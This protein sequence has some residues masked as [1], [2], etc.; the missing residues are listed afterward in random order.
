MNSG[1]MY[2][3]LTA[4]E[5]ADLKKDS[6]SKADVVWRAEGVIGTLKVIPRLAGV[7][8]KGIGTA[9]VADG[10]KGC[11]GQFCFVFSGA[12]GDRTRL[13]WSGPFWVAKGRFKFWI[14][15]FC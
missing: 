8:A 14:F 10:L 12:G 11:K 1:A 4:R 13:G 5:I 9:G 7:G 2:P 15:L 3:L 6:L